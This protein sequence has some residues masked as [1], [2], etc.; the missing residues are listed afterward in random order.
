MDTNYNSITLLWDWLLGTL[1]PL[2]DAEPVRYGI[3]REVDTGSFWDVH[4]GEFGTLWRDIR[5]ATS[6]GDRIRYLA[7]PPGWA[8]NG[9]GR[10]VSDLKRELRAGQA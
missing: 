6:W 5:N 9:T 8:P 10:M 4:F 2:Q 3:T 1:Q 7:K